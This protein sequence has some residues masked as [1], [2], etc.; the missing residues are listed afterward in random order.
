MVNLL[1]TFYSLVNGIDPYISFKMA[2]IESNMDHNAISRTNDGGLFQLNRRYY[3]FHNPKWIFSPETN[4]PIALNTLGFL[5]KSCKHHKDN[6]Y[7]LCYNRGLK[8]A[9][10]VK[11]P[12]KDMYYRK[13]NIIW[14]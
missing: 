8:G 11:N 12:L 2:K 14:K 4:I 5:K 10:K 13:F 6:L 3:K 1:I 9:S 7:V